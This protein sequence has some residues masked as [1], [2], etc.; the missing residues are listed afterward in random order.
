[1]P[2][3]ASTLVSGSPSPGRPASKLSPASAITMVAAPARPRACRPRARSTIATMTGA[4]PIV[5]KVARLTEVSDM[6]AK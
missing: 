6:A 1:M 5:T 3:P 4:P 2:V